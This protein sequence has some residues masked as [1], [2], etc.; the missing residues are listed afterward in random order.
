[1]A[2]YVIFARHGQTRWNVDG[3][4]QGHQGDSLTDKGRQQARQLAEE[5]AEEY[6]DIDV[7]VSSD[8]ARAK[9]TAEIVATVVKAPLEFDPRLRECCF[10]QLEG[11]NHQQVYAQHSRE[12]YSHL[13][14]RTFEYDFR[15]YGGECRAQVIA[16][17]VTLIEELRSNTKIRT[18]LLIGHGRSL[19]NLLMK[20]WP[21]APIING[22]CVYR[23][24]MLTGFEYH[25]V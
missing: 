17:H 5:L 19:N 15:P 25:L 11:L 2:S 6:D 3:R 22:N 20:F 23:L 10:G 24:V 9:E 14:D 12:L 4:I 1:M 16:R 18:A 13:N 7:I 8:L 21:R